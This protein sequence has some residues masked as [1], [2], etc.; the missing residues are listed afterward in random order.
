[1]NVSPVTRFFQDVGLTDARLLALLASKS[2]TSPVVD[3][4][5][6]RAGIKVEARMIAITMGA[7]TISLDRSFTQGF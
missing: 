4:T 6:A 2:R 1:M 5:L 7:V 3:K